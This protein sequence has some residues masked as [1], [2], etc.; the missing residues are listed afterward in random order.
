MITHLLFG[1]A[2]GMVLMSGFSLYEGKTKGAVCR[3][4]S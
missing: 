1:V 2:M 3:I 4:K